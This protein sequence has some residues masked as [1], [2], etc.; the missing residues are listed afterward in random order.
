[1]N[2]DLQVRCFVFLRIESYFAEIWNLSF[3]IIWSLLHQHNSFV[4]WRQ[5]RLPY[6]VSVKNLEE[7]KPVLLNTVE[8]LKWPNNLTTTFEHHSYQSRKNNT[9]S[10][11][12]RISVLHC[13]TYILCFSH[14]KWK[15]LSWNLNW[16]VKCQ[17]FLLDKWSIF[18]F[19]FLEFIVFCA[20]FT[21]TQI[22]RK[23]LIT[24]FY[25]PSWCKR[26]GITPFETVFALTLA[27]ITGRPCQ[28]IQFISRKFWRPHTRHRIRRRTESSSNIYDF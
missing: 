1:M 22:D 14:V 4:W 7:E 21:W 23:V 18:K 13:T 8:T 3:V 19:S 5:G 17:M 12:L 11:Y 15:V 2:L 16:R 27:I 9:F 25:L 6:L 20:N 10:K 28:F 26:R 24:S